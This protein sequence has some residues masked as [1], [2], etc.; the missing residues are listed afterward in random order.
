MLAPGFS[1]FGVMFE[2]SVPNRSTYTTSPTTASRS[3]VGIGNGSWSGSVMAVPSDSNDPPFANT[4][5]AGANTSRPWNVGAASGSTGMEM[6]VAFKYKKE[7]SPLSGARKYRPKRVA[8]STRR[9][10]PTPASTTAT[11]TVPSGKNIQVRLRMYCAARTSPGDTSWVI[12][13]KVAFGAYVESTPFI[14]AT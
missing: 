7:S 6:N 1:A 14:S 8:P 13:T 5:A 9:S 12:S 4:P 2:I 11:Y 3:V 10:V